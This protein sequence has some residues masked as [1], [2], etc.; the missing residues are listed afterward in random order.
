MPGG[1]CH[2]NQDAEMLKMLM[3]QNDTMLKN[4]TALDTN[5]VRGGFFYRVHVK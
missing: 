5:A 1:P 2:K 3:L 4:D